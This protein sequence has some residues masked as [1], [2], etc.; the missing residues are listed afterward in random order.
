MEEHD[1]GSTE[2]CSRRCGEWIWG[3]SQIRM[4]RWTIGRKEWFTGFIT[5]RQ[6]RPRHQFIEDDREEGEFGRGSARGEKGEKSP[7]IANVALTS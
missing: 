4:L 5:I 2:G 3:E 7:K 6:N 1:S